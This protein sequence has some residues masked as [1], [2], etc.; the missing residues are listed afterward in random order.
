MKRKLLKRILCFTIC[1]SLIW[2]LFSEPLFQVSA[3]SEETQNAIDQAEDEKEQLEKELKEQEDNK[4]QLE[5]QKNTAEEKLTNLNAQYKSISSDLAA[6]DKKKTAKE[7]EIEV[8]TKELEEAI[9]IQERQYENMKLRIQYM[10]EKPEDDLF[11]LFLKD[12]SIIEIL[13]RVDNTMKIQ[14]Y[15]R[16]QL[17]EYIANSEAL[18]Q[19]K[20]ELE[21]AKAELEGLIDES[22]K[23]QAK[24]SK[25][26]KETTA[27]ISEFVKQI[28][29]AEAQIGNTE[30]ALKE[31][32]AL[33]KQLE[34]KAKAEEAE[35]NRRKAEEEAR[36]LQEALANGTIKPG[37]SGIVYGEL[38][39]SQAEIDMLTAMIYCEARGESYEGQ[40][41]VGYVIMNRVR[42]TKF[43]NSS[44]GVLS[45]PRQFE[46]YGTGRYQTVLAAYWE[47]LDGY[48]HKSSWESCQRAAIV[49]VNSESNVGE[50]LFFR[51]HKPVPQLAE[52]LAAAGVP[53]WIIGNHIFYYR[54]VNY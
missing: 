38:N 33:L 15:D 8:K 21:A 20:Q 32:I 41:A 10:Y 12:F 14:E 25:L 23:Q 11:G 2:G 24:V 48:I 9:E 27:T 4:G 54:W 34:A 52:N 37:D 44:E 6:L 43:P 16:A 30:E 35:A 31:K 36:R 29:D 1:G 28:T 51:T 17:E 53:Y 26:Q 50:C 49:C 47:G 39:L 22:K 7:E 45:A 46:P 42:S 40:L 3:V 5:G 19:Q 13:N 18:E